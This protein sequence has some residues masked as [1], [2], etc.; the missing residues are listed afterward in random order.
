M[1]AHTMQEVNRQIRKNFIDAY[2]TFGIL[3]GLPQNEVTPGA[4]SWG[5]RAPPP[6]I[7]GANFT[8]VTVEYIYLS[9]NYLICNF[10]FFKLRMSKGDQS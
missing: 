8:T 3:K 10:F 7:S 1:I 9:E 5:A 4:Y 6:R 2:I